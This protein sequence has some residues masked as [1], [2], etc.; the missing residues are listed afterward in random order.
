M[1]A[2]LRAHWP[3]LTVFAIALVAL[4]RVATEHWREGSAT[5]AVAVLVAAGLRVALPPDRVGLLAVRGRYVDAIVYGALGLAVLLLA[6]TITR[7]SLT[8]S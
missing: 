4:Q 7:G 1:R 3:L 5:F 6:L 2:R 8:V